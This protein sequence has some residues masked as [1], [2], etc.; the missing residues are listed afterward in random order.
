MTEPR[1]RGRPRA[2][3]D[4]SAETTLQSVD[5]ALAVLSV[6]A[7]SGG[8]ALSPLA[9]RAGLPPTTA[10][11]LLSTLARHGMVE[12]DPAAQAWAVGAGAFRLGSAFLRRT[13]VM[14]RARPFLRALME[15]TGETANLGIERGDAVLFVA[16]V[17]THETIRAFFPPGTQS[18][19]YASGIGKALLARFNPDRLAAFLRRVPRERFT[20]ATLVDEAALRADLDAIRARGWA[21]DNEE[22]TAGM[23]CVAA[24]VVNA[25]GDAVAGLSVSGP[26]ARLPDAALPELGARVAAAAA[27]LSAA[28]GAGPG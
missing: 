1:R 20:P 3:R 17:E 8:L 14:D 5:R 24:A 26:A 15:A 13:S 2:F 27:G 7:E 25:Q 22:R 11:R 19:L 18:P 10:H 21:L 12:F 4:T 28:L 9:A 6:L 16:Q 23:R